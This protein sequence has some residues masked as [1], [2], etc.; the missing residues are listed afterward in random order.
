MLVR[1]RG[2]SVIASVPRSVF[3]ECRLRAEEARKANGRI[4]VSLA[5][6]DFPD[7]RPGSLSTVLE[8]KMAHG[9][10]THFLVAYCHKPNSP[11]RFRAIA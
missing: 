1:G 3:I 8:T 11:A 4:I 9:S 5:I 10:K 2:G 7:L 6:S